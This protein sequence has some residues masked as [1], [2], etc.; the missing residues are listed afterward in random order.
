MS[1]GDR[2]RLV[3]SE[4]RDFD[5]LSREIEAPV[6]ESTSWRRETP[7]DE[8]QETQTA[9]EEPIG[10][11]SQLASML[12]IVNVTIGSGLLAMPFAM[13]TS[14]L[15]ASIMLQALFVTLIIIT[16]IMCTELTVKT[17]VDSYH[18]MVQEHCHRYVYQLTQVAIMLMVYGAVVAFL[19]TIGD[20]FDRFFASLYGP[21]FCYHWYMNRKFLVSL[22]TVLVINP[23]CCVKTVGFL[24]YGR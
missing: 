4:S 23:L 3:D 18:R 15:L 11:T 12:I 21:S 5:R 16:C 8:V 22:V 13:Q 17:Q 19:V 1:R 7:L 2:A 9:P 20:Q 10:Y 14:G 6:S 24:K